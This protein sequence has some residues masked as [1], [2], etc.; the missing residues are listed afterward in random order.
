[1][2]S[3]LYPYP[4]GA[5]GL[6]GRD[7]TIRTYAILPAEQMGEE[8]PVHRWQS[9]TSLLRLTYPAGFRAQTHGDST[10]SYCE[11]VAILG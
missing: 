1:M 3:I 7:E 9:W 6:F 2:L 11:L 4:R 10:E 5:Q 8:A